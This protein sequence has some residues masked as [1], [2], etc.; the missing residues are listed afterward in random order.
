VV[1]LATGL[2]SDFNWLPSASGYDSTGVPNALIL[3]GMASAV[4]EPSSWA[5]L[6]LGF[7]AIVAAAYRRRSAPAAAAPVFA[8]LASSDRDAALFAAPPLAATG[9]YADGMKLWC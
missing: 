1:A 2:N 8:P 5:M 7:A 9:P 4:P 6:M 3:T